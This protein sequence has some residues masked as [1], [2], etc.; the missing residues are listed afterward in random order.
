MLSQSHRVSQYRFLCVLLVIIAILALCEFDF[1][2]DMTIVVDRYR[3]DRR[4]VEAAHFQ[5]AV[6]QVASWYPH[7]LELTKLRLHG[8]I[9]ATLSSVVAS[10]HGLFMAQYSS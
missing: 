7:Q 10:Y 1:L 6:L 4:R 5:F 8:G 3:L 2:R 9:D